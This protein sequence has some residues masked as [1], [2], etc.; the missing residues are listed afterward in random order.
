MVPP[1]VPLKV[2]EPV[3]TSGSRQADAQVR[4]GDHGGREEGREGGREGE[5]DAQVRAGDEGGGREGVVPW[6]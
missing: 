4:L 1:P 3:R 5:G 2:P 6:C